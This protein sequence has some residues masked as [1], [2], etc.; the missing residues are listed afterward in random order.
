MLTVIGLLAA[1]LTVAFGWPQI[2]RV[3]R[4]GDVDGIALP[5]V[6]AG[7][8]CG[9]FWG[10]FGLLTADAAQISCNVVAL[11]GSAVLLVLIHRRR[12]ITL[13]TAAVAAVVLVG[14]AATGWVLGGAPALA[15]VAAG[16]GVLSQLPQLRNALAGRVA[17]VSVPAFVVLVAAQ[18]SWCVYGLGQGTV[19]VWA[20][21]AAQALIAVA[22]AA[23]TGWHQ[24]RVPLLLAAELAPSLAPAV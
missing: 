12:P 16:I 5:A 8:G 21:A 1:F 22:V 2:L 9:V 23:L 7:V 18:A 20:A 11:A 13:T 10:G 19:Q 3:A 17:G 14:G 15:T 24:R 6:F 4:T